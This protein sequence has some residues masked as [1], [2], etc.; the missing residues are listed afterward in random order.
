ME[1]QTNSVKDKNLIFQKLLKA[2]LNQIS[3]D[4]GFCSSGSKSRCV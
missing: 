1:K 3:M 2:F 4:D